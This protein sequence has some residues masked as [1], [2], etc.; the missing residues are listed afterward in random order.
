M[1]KSG[2][3][4]AGRSGRR[5]QQTMGM[6]FGVI[7]SIILIVVFII[8][9]GIVVKHFLG[10]KKCSEISIF[11]KDFQDGIDKVWKSSSRS[12]AFP[13]GLPGGIQEVCFVDFNKSISSKYSNVK[14]RY[15]FY[16]PNFFFYPP[17]EACE[18][19]YYTFKHINVTEAI[20]REGNPFCIENS[21]GF[22]DA[23][24][25]KLRISKD[26]YDSLVKIEAG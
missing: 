23:N 9:A 1:K 16:Q 19:S 7:F 17:E 10:L 4:G 3:K 20:E 26:F 24:G 15:A 2:F 6:P 12:E 5:A 13:I 11:M 8:V 14:T 18:V 25:K 22:G 21:G